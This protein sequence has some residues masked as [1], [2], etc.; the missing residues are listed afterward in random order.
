MVVERKLP[1]IANKADAGHQIVQMNIISQDKLE[2]IARIAKTEAEPM[3]QIVEMHITTQAPM[4]QNPRIVTPDLSQG[5]SFIT[6]NVAMA[7][8]AVASAPVD[9][10]GVAADNGGGIGLLGSS[11]VDMS[12][13]AVMSSSRVGSPTSISNLLE[14]ALGAQSSNSNILGRDTGEMKDS[15]IPSF[16]GE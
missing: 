15:G 9:F 3:G 14:M 2:P 16:V 11:H 10:S 4:E 12:D 1:L 6:E 7:S 13:N 8:Q 5:E